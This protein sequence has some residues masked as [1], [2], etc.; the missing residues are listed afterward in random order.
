MAGQAHPQ[1]FEAARVGLD[2][3]KHRAAGVLDHL[4]THRH[5]AKQHEDQTAQRVDLFLVDLIRVGQAQAD[6]GLE[7]LQRGAGLRDIDARRLL[8]PEMTLVDVMLILDLTH[9]LFDQILDRDQP[10][11][12]AIFIDH[13]RQMHALA[14][15]LL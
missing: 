7:F 8:G 12:P 1:A 13:Q 5:P 6:L 14:L 2:H 15:H 4:A 3:L 11:D 9:D 10:V